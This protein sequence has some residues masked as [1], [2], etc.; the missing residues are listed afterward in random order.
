MPM[1]VQNKTNTSVLVR[2][3]SGATVHLRAWE[4]SAELEDVEVRDNPRIDVLAERGLVDLVDADDEDHEDDEPGDHVAT[5]G[6]SRARPRGTGSSSR[7]S[8]ARRQPAS[9]ERP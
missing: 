7:R 4:T 6:S 5:S 8:S 2:L 3:R 9:E 1:R